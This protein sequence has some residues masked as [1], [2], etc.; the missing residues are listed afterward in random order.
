MEAVTRLGRV[1]REAVELVKLAT[2]IAIA[3][4]G[5][6]MMGIVDTAVVGRVG[7]TEL[8]AV[9]LAAA[10]YFG[11]FCFGIG[12]MLGMDP[13]ISQALGAKDPVRAR[14]LFWLG[15]RLA[16]WTGLLV[17]VPLFVVPLFLPAMGVSE[18]ISSKAT[19]YLWWRLPGIIPMLWFVN[20]RGYLQALKNPRPLVV[21][22][23]IANVANVFFDLALVFGGVGMVGALQSG[24]GVDAQFLLPYV[25][26][27]PE[28]GVTGAALA[29]VLCTLLQLGIVAVSINRHRVAN[30]PADL[31]KGLPADARRAVRVGVPIGLHML[32]EVGVF[33]VA[34]ILAA[35]IGA[36]SGG[37]HQV[38][39]TLASFSFTFAVGIG[40]AGSVRVGYAVGAGDTPG[41]RRAGFVAIWA[42]GL[43]MGVSALGMLL[44]PEAVVRLMTKDP[45]VIASAVPLMVVAAAFQVSDGV[46]GVGAGVLRGAGDSHFTFLANLVG[47]WAI[48][49]PLALYLAFGT[50]LGITGLWWG[51]CAGLTAVAVAIVYR[52][53][54][55]SKQTIRP[56]T[57]APVPAPVPNVG[58]APAPE[59]AI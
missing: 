41:A 4:A 50:S 11:F 44:W 19:Q 47:H 10:V 43:F 25:R 26:W 42:G 20:S 7:A 38:A 13:L 17:A 6:A 33:S 54:R 21:A 58:T 28:M 16:V 12:L 23:V 35:R 53:N 5:L 39:I 27:I 8:A 49:L 14:R 37:A 2:P 45:G 24:L 52:F 34:G 22:T 57:Q 29:T 56:L 55:L 18:E 9:G 32:A 36:E 15:N 31:R 46:Q 51:L 1:R 40:N 3:Q 48:G 30:L 59:I